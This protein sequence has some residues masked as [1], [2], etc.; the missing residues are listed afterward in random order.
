MKRLLTAALITFSFFS[1]GDGDKDVT[2]VDKGKDTTA[3]QNGNNK[4]AISPEVIK[5]FV[6]RIPSP[7]VISS[8]IKEMKVEYDQTLLNSIDNESKYNSDHRRALNLG[9]YSTDLGYANIYE[10]S[11]DA[12]NLI[13]GVKD[14]ADALQIGQYFEFEKIKELAKSSDKLD[15][16]L[17]V[18]E[19]NLQKV[20]EKLQEGNRSDMTVLIIT[21]GWVEVMYLATNVAKKKK[22]KDLEATIGEQ[23]VVLADLVNLLNYYEASPKMKELHD[24]LKELQ[25]IYEGV[26]ETTIE[27][28]DKQTEKNGEVVVE[29]G[30]RT[31]IEIPQE[32]LDKIT[33]KIT[34]IR[35]KIVN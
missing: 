28:E 8:L 9:V 6:E 35:S 18:T 30:S 23:K 16:L 11:Q 20:N 4:D 32:V 34:S 31:E 12:I 14:M 17:R 15:E 24:E 25:K 1:C 26:K 10:K 19:E 33:E 13:T 3:K 2:G 29:Q 5:S 27:G 21:G 7:M 22:N